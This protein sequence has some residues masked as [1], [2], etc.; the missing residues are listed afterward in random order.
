MAIEAGPCFGAALRFSC[1]CALTETILATALLRCKIAANKRL[2]REKREAKVIGNRLKTL[3]R[4]KL[5][6]LEE[7]CGSAVQLREP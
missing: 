4:P 1:G 3:P 6:D 2:H 5:E 7:P